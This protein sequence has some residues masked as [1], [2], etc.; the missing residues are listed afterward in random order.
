[1]GP[2]EKPVGLFDLDI[3]KINVWILGMVRQAR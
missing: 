2:L 1:M 3:T